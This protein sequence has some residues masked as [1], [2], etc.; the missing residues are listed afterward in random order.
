MIGDALEQPDEI[1]VVVAE[2]G[3]S[4]QQ[5]GLGERRELAAIP[6]SHEAASTPSIVAPGADEACR[7]RPDSR[8]TA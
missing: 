7:R 5:R 3:G 2:C 1:A 4:R 6:A 8:R